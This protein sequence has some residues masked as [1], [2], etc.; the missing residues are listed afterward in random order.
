MAKTTAPNKP[1]HVFFSFGPGGGS[2]EADLQTLSPNVVV[3]AAHLAVRSDIVAP[4]GGTYTIALRVDGVD[5]ALACTVPSG[6]TTCN[7]G[8][9]SVVIPAASLL[10]LGL[11]TSGFT[12]SFPTI[13]IGVET[14]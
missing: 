4:S 14:H 13:S 3:T 8:T 1:A 7:S 9:A 6:A 5:T 12:S 11:T 10:S 2:T